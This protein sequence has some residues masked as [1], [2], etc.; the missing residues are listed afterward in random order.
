MKAV[1]NGVNKQFLA[2]A[3]VVSQTTGLLVNNEISKEEY[4]QPVR[5]IRRWVAISPDSGHVLHNIRFEVVGCWRIT[6]KDG[7]YITSGYR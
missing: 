2:G 6:L 3:H 7:A 4:K 5:Y 1:S